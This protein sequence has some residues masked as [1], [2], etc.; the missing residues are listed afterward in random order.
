[1][2]NIFFTVEVWRDARYKIG[3]K[4]KREFGKVALWEWSIKQR[5][6]LR[7]SEAPVGIACIGYSAFF[8]VVFLAAV[9][10]AG[11]SFV[12]SAAGSSFFLAAFFAV[13]FLAGFSAGSSEAV[14]SSVFFFAVFFAGFSSVV[15]S[16][17]S[18]ACGLYMSKFSRLFS[19]R[20]ENHFSIFFMSLTYTRSSSISGNTPLKYSLISLLLAF[21]ASGIFALLSFIF[22]N[23]SCRRTLFPVVYISLLGRGGTLCRRAEMNLGDWSA[24]FFTIAPSLLVAIS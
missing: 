1:M 4:V 2:S 21:F 7:V 8:L 5:A 16:A 18:S 11:F 9:F 14:G 6:P 24:R 20:M 22:C 3:T 15:S 12:S 23:T 13:V 17:V 10:L 19:P